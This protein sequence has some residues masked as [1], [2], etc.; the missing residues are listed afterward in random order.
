M[1]TKW[2]LFS[3]RHV[4]CIHVHLFCFFPYKAKIS[5][6]CDKCDQ[7]TCET[8]GVCFS[9]VEQQRNGDLLY[10]YR[11]TNFFFSILCFIYRSLG[12]DIWLQTLLLFCLVCPV[13]W[14]NWACFHQADR[15]GV[16]SA[17][18][19]RPLGHHRPWAVDCVVEMPTFV[20][21]PITR[22]KS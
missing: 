8:D 2:P 6:H 21:A 5:C 3:T 17:P 4:L 11:Y 1:C 7:K 19:D 22:L 13:V 10:S 20:I 16:I 14:V 9:S 15:F 12:E 18:V